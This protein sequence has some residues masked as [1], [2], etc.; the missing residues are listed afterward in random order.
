MV[1]VIMDTRDGALLSSHASPV[2]P[3]LYQKRGVARRAMNERCRFALKHKVICQ[4]RIVID[5]PVEDSN[6]ALD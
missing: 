2:M 1:Y 6:G 3:A 5:K 4:A